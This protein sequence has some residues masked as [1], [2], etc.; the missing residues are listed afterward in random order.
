MPAFP[1]THLSVVQALG[2]ADPD[3]RARAAELVARAYRAPLLS[4]L[5][6]RWNLEPADAEDLVQEFLATAFQKE[7]LARFDPAR[8]R[9]RTFLRVAAD[10]FAANQRQ[11]ERRLKRGGD[12]ATV[13]LDV[14]TVAGSDGDAEAE[15]RFREEW[16][17]SVLALAVERLE[18]ESRERGR[19]VHFAL[20]TA[21]DLAEEPRPTY[22]EL[23]LR[24]A[25]GESQVINHLAWARRRFRAH[26]LDVLRTLAGSEQEYRDD[27]QDLLGI[28]AP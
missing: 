11:A 26:A 15:R 10:R 25:L 23:G 20:F 8:G 24:H 27:V 22:R 3:V 2:G 18:T 14:V 19:A 12:A 7:W 16:V 28:T 5:Q 13:G 4:V 1:D 17:R 6:W 21:Y 9:F